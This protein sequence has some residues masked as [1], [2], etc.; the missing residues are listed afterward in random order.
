[1]DNPSIFVPLEELKKQQ[2]EPE[3]P[4]S[5]VPTNTSEEH[6]RKN[7]LYIAFASIIGIGLVGFILFKVIL[8]SPIPQIFLTTYQQQDTLA[9]KTLEQSVIDYNLLGEANKNEN[10]EQAAQI[11]AG[12][13]KQVTSNT[14]RLDT[15]QRTTVN[16]KIL[17]AKITSSTVREKVL[18][19]FGMLENRNNRLQ[20]VN[21]TQQEM[22]AALLQ[23]YTATEQGQQA[24]LENIDQVIGATQ[25]ELK[26]INQLQFQIDSL[27]DEIIESAG[28]DRASL[29]ASMQSI[30]ATLSITPEPT[31][32][33]PSVTA[34]P[35]ATVVPLPPF[36]SPSVEPALDTLPPASDE[37]SLSATAIPEPTVSTPE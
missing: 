9:K 19:L 12:Y 8:Q 31:L 13:A 33:R 4:F 32:A 5:A 14:D 25:N 34:S 20:T 16:L 17:S 6:D 28:V 1:M 36:A 26:D 18:K 35:S 27:F 2:T 23:H 10:R 11:V 30:E 7:G 22:F 37:S 24:Q 29:Q 21:K 15:L 3:D